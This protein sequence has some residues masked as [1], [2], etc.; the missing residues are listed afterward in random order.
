MPK[1][2]IVLIT[3]AL[4]SGKTT[5]LQR[6]IDEVPLKLAVL[7]NEFG[8][9]GIDGTVIRAKNVNLIELAGGCVCCELTGEFEAAVTELMQTMQPQM[10]V[11]E[12]TGVAESD[13]LVLEVE[14]SISGVRLD[15]VIYLADAYTSL[16]Y[17]QVGYVARNQLQAADVVLINKIDLVAA[18]RLQAIETQ[19]RQFNSRAAI[20]PTAFA[21][22]DVKML[23]GTTG[24][25]RPALTRTHRHSV[26]LTQLS[27]RSH[28]DF[29]RTAFETLLAGLA[30]GVVRAKG[31]I[32]LDGRYH[33]LNQVGDR[34]TLE[35]V[36]ADATWLVFIG[37]GLE[38]VKDRLIEAIE[39]CRNLD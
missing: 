6:F 18:D 21:E 3:G 26:E 38:P 12:A 13:A 16:K 37:P 33:L 4:G 2:P 36:A 30:P 11:V 27:Y 5:L 29:S 31:F 25:P 28:N 32:R 8:E 19:I 10:I 1:M 22:V 17:P 23:L 20:L 14:E 9:I 35:P 24:Q 34:F 15:S 7:V 39:A